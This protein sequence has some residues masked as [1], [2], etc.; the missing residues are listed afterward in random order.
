MCT[1][2]RDFSSGALG[3]QGHKD[4]G[5][6]ITPWSRTVTQLQLDLREVIILLISSGAVGIR[7]I[8]G[9]ELGIALAKNFIASS[10]FG[11]I[12]SLL[13]ILSTIVKK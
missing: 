7:L 3:I 11:V 13:F 12:V 2:I 8:F 9:N 4:G 10:V 6:P 5:R 1:C